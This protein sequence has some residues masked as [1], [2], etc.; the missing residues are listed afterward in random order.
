[1]SSLPLAPRAEPATRPKWE[2]AA[3]FL[4]RVGEAADFPVLSAHVE[5]VMLAPVEELSIQ[6]LTS[7]ILKD[8]GMTMK[9]LRTANSALYNRSGQTVLSV[10]HA[11][12]LLGTDA[13]RNQVGGLMLFE[14]FERRRNNAK[15]LRELMVLALLTA[16]HAREAAVVV[17][18]P[19]REEAYLCGMIRNLGELMVAAY[20]PEEYSLALAAMHLDHNTEAAAAR[21]ILGFRY[22]EL[23]VAAVERWRLPASASGVLRAV[24]LPRYMMRRQLAE[25][26][27]LAGITLFAH[28]LTQA[29]YRRESSVARASVRL[30]VEEF[31]PMFAFS[32]D[33]VRQIVERGLAETRETLDLFRVPLDQLRLRKQA[34]DALAPEPEAHEGDADLA[35]LEAL[36]GDIAVHADRGG[37]E[38]DQ[39]I[40]MALEAI[41]RGAGF[42]RAVFADWDAAGRRM[43]ARSALG[44]GAGGPPGG[45]TFAAAGDGPVERAAAGEDVFA[46]EGDRRFEGSELV[47]RLAPSMFG[48]YGVPGEGG[49]AGFLY[50]DRRTPGERPTPAVL[51]RLAWVRDQL[52]RALARGG[53]P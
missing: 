20:A 2:N 28:R 4:E 47:A 11:V 24:E 42:D 23:A 12:S 25:Q 27:V 53:R 13:V 31:L 39:I 49:L 6:H 40:S 14:H 22:E 19:R 3:R 26:D 29:V 1:M 15:N 33:D 16:A 51:E 38:A 32:P 5:R 10:S 21:K 37:S 9:I 46:M 18:F 34:E 43:V 17:R 30:V 35:L 8:Y 7:V 41:V 52:A 50:F 48:L 36:A 44:E 45:F